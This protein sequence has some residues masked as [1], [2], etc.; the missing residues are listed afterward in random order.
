M[1][2][3]VGLIGVAGY[4]KNHLH[5]LRDCTDQGL[6]SIE[7]AVIRN[8]ESPEVKETIDQFIQEGIRIYPSFTEL[9]ENEKDQCD[10]ISIPCGIHEHAPMSIAAMNS[11]FHVLC[12]KP[13]AGTAEE[14]SAMADT[15]RD[16]GKLL[17]VGYQNIFSPSI[18]KIKR[19]AIEETLGKLISAK[20]FALWP[21]SESY[22][23][24][25]SWAGKQFFQGK[26]INDSPIQNAV[27]HY[28]HILLYISGET[29]SSASEPA[30]VYGENYRAQDIESADTQCIRV[31]TTSGKKLFFIASHACTEKEGPVTEF[32]FEKGLVTWE[33]DG[34]TKV[35]DLE[36]KEIGRFDNAGVNIHLEVYR[37]TFQAVNGGPQPLC[38]I[39]NAGSHVICSNLCFQSSRGIHQ[40]PEQYLKHQEDADDFYNKMVNSSSIQSSGDRNTCIPGIDEIVH[41]MFRED[42]CFSEMDLPWAV[43]SKIVTL[44]R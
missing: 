22:Y 8:S 35:F 19:M 14:V 2:I 4:G 13:A 32:R 17:A 24:R 6:C 43:P 44:D 34:L 42:R 25:N 3:R 41:T 1:K 28:L 37:N 33:M 31:T 15:Q 12:E 7:A 16:T 26:M 10:L 21:R 36:R 40:I 11:G 38:T 20:S 30:S 39:H 9:I 29:M 5:S 27:A 23:S 18:Q